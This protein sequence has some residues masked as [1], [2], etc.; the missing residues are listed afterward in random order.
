MALYRKSMAT[1]S[2][3]AKSLQSCLTLRDPVDCSPPSSSV[4]G[5]PQAGIL[6]WVA[7]PSSR[8]SSQP[9]DWTLVS[10]I[11]GRFFIVLLIYIK[12]MI[13]T[14]IHTF[15]VLS[16]IR[17]YQIEDLHVDQCVWWQMAVEKIYQG[18]AEFVLSH[19]FWYFLIYQGHRYIFVCGYISSTL[20]AI[21]FIN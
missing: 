21:S 5:I 17:L 9:R 7:M 12:Y 2:M 19:G 16:F 13:N 1:P 6:E 3:C 8:G 15:R 20:L 18:L 10:H 4:Y 11:A 14:Y